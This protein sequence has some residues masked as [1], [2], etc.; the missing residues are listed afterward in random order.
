[1]EKYFA[2]QLISQNTTET[3]TQQSLSSSKSSGRDLLYHVLTAVFVI[4]PA[5]NKL[6][7]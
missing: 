6:L 1:M 2:L 3:K 7:L 5:V 4:L